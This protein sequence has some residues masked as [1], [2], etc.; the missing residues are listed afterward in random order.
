MSATEEQK[1]LQ[2]NFEEIARLE[3]KYKV[4]GISFAVRPGENIGTK[5][6]F[7]IIKKLI[8]RASKHINNRKSYPSPE[9]SKFG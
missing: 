5:E 1:R 2:D 7:G 3:K 9:A 4:K 6:S 8:P